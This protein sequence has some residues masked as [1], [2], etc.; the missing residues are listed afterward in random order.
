MFDR[1]QAMINEIVD[2]FDFS[3][4]E[5]VM[6]C[7]NWKL[8]VPNEVLEYKIPNEYELRKMARTLLYDAVKNTLN[9]LETE[10]QDS[11]YQYVWS[12]P[13]KV[14]ILKER[15]TIYSI[16][17]D[18]VCES[19]DFYDYDI[20]DLV[21]EQ[22]IELRNQVVDTCDYTKTTIWS[23]ANDSIDYQKMID[24]TGWYSNNTLDI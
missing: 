9:L 7:L 15:G 5:K 12:G 24:N 21:E 16:V 1:E 10:N 11:D 14:T 19:Y 17:L 13:F 4:V 20:E 23:E 2:G 3:K 18:F 8:C 6:T 22:K